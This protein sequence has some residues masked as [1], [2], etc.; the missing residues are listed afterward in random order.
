MYS[1]KYYDCL[2]TKWCLFIA[3]DRIRQLGLGPA[4]H[5]GGVFEKSY[6]GVNDGSPKAMLPCSRRD[7]SV[8]SLVNRIVL[9]K[10][11]FHASLLGSILNFYAKVM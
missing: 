9:D 8:N 11:N 1:C 7:V 10:R 5:H 6:A 2:Q 3:R 4:G